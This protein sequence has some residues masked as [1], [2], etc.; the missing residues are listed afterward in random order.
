MLVM[1]GFNYLNGWNS[2]EGERLDDIYFVNVTND[3]FLFQHFT[4]P[5]RDANRL[6]FL[7]TTDEKLVEELRS[8]HGRNY[9]KK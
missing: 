9:Q 7:L 5:T 1:G 3:N 6:D 8:K 2:L 4:V